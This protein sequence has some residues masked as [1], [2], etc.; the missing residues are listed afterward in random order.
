MGLGMVNPGL[1]SG[2]RILKRYSLAAQLR[3]CGC[4]AGAEF[5]P[6]PL[7]N[8]DLIPSHY[9]ARA[10]DG[11]LPPSVGRRALPVAGWPGPTPMTRPPSLQ[12]PAYSAEAA[13]SAAKAEYR[14]FVASAR[15]SAPLRRAGTCCLA[16]GAACAF[17]LGIA[18]KVLTEL[19]WVS[20]G[21]PV[22]PVAV[23]PAQRR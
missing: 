22:L 16:V 9:P 6:E 18:G 2:F 12:P 5:H 1:N 19:G 20:V 8:P 10:I 13:A 11:K 17:S 4:R 21:R 23:G 15:Q 7:T 3:A 14:A